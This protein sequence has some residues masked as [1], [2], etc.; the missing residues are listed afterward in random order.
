MTERRK[1]D[2]RRAAWELWRPPLLGLAGVLLASLGAAALI[3]QR[4]L[5]RTTVEGA[6]AQDF[7]IFYTS[8]Q[9]YAHG[10][11][12]YAAQPPP[13][14]FFYRTGQL[15]LNLP[16]TNVFFLPLAL[17][18]PRAGFVVWV[19]ASLFVLTC[20][21]WRSL[22][23]LAWRL[24]PLAW[25]ALAVYLVAWG[26]AAAFSLTFQL[27]FLL[28]GPVTA[29][30]LAARQGRSRAAGAWLGLAAIVKPFLLLFVPF[31][32][33]RRDRR[34]LEALAAVGVGMIAIGLLVFGPGAYRDWLVQL[35][36]VTWG[37]HY[38]NASVAGLLQRLIGLSPYEHAGDLPWLRLVLL[39]AAVATVG[40]VT[41]VR[42]ARLRKDAAGVDAAWASLLL[43]S[44]LLSPLGWVYYMWIALWPV[45]AV[46]GHERPWARRTFHDLLLVPGLGGWL[47]FRKMAG[48]G[49]PGLIAS[50]T[51]ASMYFW[52]L[53]ALWWWCL[54]ETG[55]ESV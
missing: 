51:F 11:S 45:A 27:S 34:A 47:W 44:I 48:W 14:G 6:G 2:R 30:W 42:T 20:S 21:T 31:L 4:D 52:A 15:N 17:L 24:P 13:P 22:R 10:R 39:G 3:G 29:A 18:S 23:A 8:I 12:L 43:A 32:L 38:M 36:R 7:G 5:W 50:A 37:S 26:P 55:D 54:G 9:H 28:M 53:A 40:T 25:L 19:A 46:I 1:G 35:P 41:I 49:Q 33:M 16:H